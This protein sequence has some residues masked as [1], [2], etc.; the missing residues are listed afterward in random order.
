MARSVFYQQIQ[1]Y[2][3]KGYGLVCVDVRGQSP[4]DTPPK[5]DTVMANTIGE[6]KA[7]QML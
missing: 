1:D 2:E 6:K 5:E 7:E 3:N 4:M